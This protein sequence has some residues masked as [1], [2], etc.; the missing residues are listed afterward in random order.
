MIKLAKTGL[1]SV[2]LL[3]T[4]VAKASKLPWS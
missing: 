3:A 2:A 4:V 1:L